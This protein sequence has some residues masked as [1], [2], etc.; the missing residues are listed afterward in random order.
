M[1]V[2]Q[3]ADVGTVKSTY[4]RTPVLQHIMIAIGGGDTCCIFLIIA[5][6]VLFSYIGL[7][8]LPL[9]LVNSCLL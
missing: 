7:L 8:L 5:V 1:H 4:R 9:K 6:V 2:P 3:G